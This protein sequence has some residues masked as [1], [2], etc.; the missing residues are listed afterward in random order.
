MI[1]ID[2]ILP[3]WYIHFLKEYNRLKGEDCSFYFL[4]N[5]EQVHPKLAECT[6][7]RLDDDEGNEYLSIRKRTESVRDYLETHE[8]GFRGAGQSVVIGRSGF[9]NRVDEWST[10]VLLMV[11]QEGRNELYFVDTDSAVRAG[12]ITADFDSFFPDLPAALAEAGKKLAERELVYKRNEDGQLS[13]VEVNYLNI[14]ARIE[15]VKPLSSIL[16]EGRYI[17][18]DAE[19]FESIDD[20]AAL[21]DR[22]LNMTGLEYKV[23]M[24]GLAANTLRISVQEEIREIA[25][26][27]RTDC[28]DGRWIEELNA[29]IAK[30]GISGR[31]QEIYPYTVS[32]ADQTMA[33]GFCT[34]AEFEIL[35]GCGYI[36]S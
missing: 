26:G 2:R 11:K 36:E 21:T 6:L 33:I 5:L 15:P 23:S 30:T 31:F 7:L 32:H 28:F 1:V 8:P 4:L 12:L 3:D 13:P 19:G 27:L 10:S 18:F 9:C 22:L 14:E 34:Q 24:S 20:Y 25:F 17:H 16:N 35:A 29:L